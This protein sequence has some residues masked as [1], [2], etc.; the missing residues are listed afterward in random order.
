MLNWPGTERQHI[1]KTFL[2]QNK[3]RDHIVI[4][5]GPKKTEWLLILTDHPTTE[6]NHKTT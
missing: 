2:I 6:R 4:L 5:K 3:N 1:F